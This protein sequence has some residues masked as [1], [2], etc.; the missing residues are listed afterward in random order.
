MSQFIFQINRILAAASSERPGFIILT[1]SLPQVISYR[2][3]NAQQVETLTTA[4]MGMNVKVERQLYCKLLSY[5]RPR[6]PNSHYV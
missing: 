4:M 6:C 1:S 2:V 5:N 3:D